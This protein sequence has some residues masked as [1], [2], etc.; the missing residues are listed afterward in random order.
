LGV[1]IAMRLESD[2]PFV[3][4]ERLF[5]EIGSSVIATADAAKVDAIRTVL[6]EH[7]G[8]FVAP[9]G[10]VT[11]GKVEILLNDKAVI[12]EPV[13]ALKSVWSGALEAQLA[14]EVF[15]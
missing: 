3:T 1:R 10:E 8:V 13:K 9:L 11:V 5:S 15:A 14:E 12:D 4:T 6:G 7:P 2:K